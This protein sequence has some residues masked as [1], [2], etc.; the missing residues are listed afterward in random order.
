MSNIV[1]LEM[2]IKCRMRR[3]KQGEV[4]SSVHFTELY[5]KQLR[6]LNYVEETI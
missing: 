5:S 1:N 4:T 2:K 3:R 6:K